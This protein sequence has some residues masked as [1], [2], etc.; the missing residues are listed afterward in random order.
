MKTTLFILPLAV[1]ALF[2]G[3]CDNKSTSEHKEAIDSKAD[4]TEKRADAVK[5]DAEAKAH[6]AKAAGEAK[7]E[8]AKEQGKA[9]ADALKNQADQQ[10]DEKKNVDPSTTPGTSPTNPNP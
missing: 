2:I 6:E 4:A 1:A 8:Q 7:A 3:A 5:D 9:Q 10:R